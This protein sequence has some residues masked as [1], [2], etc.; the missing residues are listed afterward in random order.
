MLKYFTKMVL[1]NDKIHFTHQGEMLFNKKAE[2]KTNYSVKNI[3][4]FSKVTA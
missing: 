4:K 2:S 1:Q 3:M